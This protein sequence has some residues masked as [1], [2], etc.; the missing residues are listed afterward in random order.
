MATEAEV[1]CFYE[2]TFLVKEPAMAKETQ[3]EVQQIEDQKTQTEK[4]QEFTSTETVM[5]IPAPIP[6]KGSEKKKK[7]SHSAGRPK[8]VESP[9]CRMKVM[10]EYITHSSYQKRLSVV[11]RGIHKI[12]ATDEVRHNLMYVEFEVISVARMHHS[13]EVTT[14]DMTTILVQLVYSAQKRNSFN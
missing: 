3:T 12:L 4:D 2:R 8:T 6:K 1:W 9:T 5:E 13:I 14:A 7:R 10:N 11:L